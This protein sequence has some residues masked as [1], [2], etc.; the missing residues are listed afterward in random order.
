MKVVL[1]KDVKDLGK[2]G[3]ILNVKPGYAR[4]FLF[5]HKAA[6]LA[7][8][9]KVK[10]FEHLKQVAEAKKSKAV[11]SRKKVIESLRGVV[12]EFKVQASEADKLFGSISAL[13]I[14]K[15][16]LS[17]GFEI[18]RKDI[19]MEDVIKVLGQHKAQV[20]FGDGE[21]LQIEFIVSVERAK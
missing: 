10:E 9:R 16:L 3:D 21:D 19:H 13:D 8:E 2:V 14:S 6:V 12:V 7:T 15:Q 20:I 1:Q 18:D 4:N 5:P 17:Q 11:S